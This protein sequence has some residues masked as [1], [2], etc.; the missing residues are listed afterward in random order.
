M[1]PLLGALNL[2]VS[3]RARI[4]NFPLGAL[5][6]R[7]FMRGEPPHKNAAFMARKPRQ[8]A[9]ATFNFQLSTFNF[10]PSFLLPSFLK[11]Q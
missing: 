6:C 4:R 1:N 2:E 9:S 8:R 3:S 7:F 5:S 10:L 11:L